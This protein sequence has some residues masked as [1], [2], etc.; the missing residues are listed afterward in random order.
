MERSDGIRKKLLRAMAAHVLDHG[1]TLASLRPLAKAAGTSDRMLIYH[2]E[3]KDNLIS[4]LLE[5]LAQD[6]TSK[7]DSALPLHPV[8]SQRLLL[9]QVLA[10]VRSP[11]V[12]AYIRLWREVVATAGLGDEAHR[13]TAADI[14]AG[15]V[16]WLE[17]R[18]PT[19]EPNPGQAARAMLTVIEGIHVMDAAE[20][21]DFADEAIERLYPR[22]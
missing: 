12:G 18:M 22:R 8:P 5:T 4:A 21:T 10:L 3:S 1:L 7:L 16:A 11:V 14:I 17:V 19:D 6:F 15:F 13:R 2:F 20:L 9:D